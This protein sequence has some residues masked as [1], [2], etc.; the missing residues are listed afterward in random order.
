MQRMT[1]LVD[2]VFCIYGEQAKTWKTEEK[3]QGAQ[4]TLEMYS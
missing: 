1:E 3:M 4:R 2:R